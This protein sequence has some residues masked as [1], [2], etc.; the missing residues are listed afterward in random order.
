MNDRLIDIMGSVQRWLCE[1]LDQFSCRWR[2]H[3]ARGGWFDPV[4]YWFMNRCSQV[5][6]LWNRMEWWMRVRGWSPGF[7]GA[8]TG[9]GTGFTA[10]H[11]LLATGLLLPILLCVTIS[12]WTKGLPEPAPF[13][14]DEIAMLERLAA[15]T[16]RPPQRKTAATRE[17][18]IKR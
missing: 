2:L 15:P 11:A 13:T 10:R 4:A 8:S 5:Q 7:T 12:W 17:I 14:S 3:V 9:T 1:M 16:P 6:T 18:S